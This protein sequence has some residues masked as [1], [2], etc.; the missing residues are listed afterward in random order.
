M[1][2]VTIEQATG[3]V[4]TWLIPTLAGLIG[5]AIGGLASI[6]SAG[7]A[8]QH[9]VVMLR[10]ERREAAADDLLA[11]LW[12]VINQSTEVRWVRDARDDGVMIPGQDPQVD[13]KA[14]MGKAYDLANRCANDETHVQALCH[15]YAWQAGYRSTWDEFRAWSAALSAAITQWRRSCDVPRPEPTTAGLSGRA[16]GG[17]AQARR[18]Q[19]RGPAEPGH[20]GVARVD[21]AL[22]CDDAA[23]HTCVEMQRRLHNPERRT[24]HE[25]VRRDW[26]CKVGG[27]QSAA[28]QRVRREVASPCRRSLVET[29][30]TC[31]STRSSVSWSREMTTSHAATGSLLQACRSRSTEATGR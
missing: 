3:G 16:A 26:S 11:A 4:L 20:G 27:P 2:H 31:D 19:G 10:L 21:P 7:L 29:A 24:L 12:H 25:R 14:V 1:I 5:A 13:R 30:G 17:D 8:N 23:G 28:C 18:G 22:T 6:L 15:E 9:A